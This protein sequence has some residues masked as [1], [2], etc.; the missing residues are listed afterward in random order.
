MFEL[1]SK[2][3]KNLVWLNFSKHV[4]AREAEAVIGKAQGILPKLN[5]GFRLVTDLSGLESM[6]LNC[7]PH[8]KKL[9]EIWNK[10]GVA[11]VI[12]IIPD[13]SKDI[14]L[15]IMS[16][17]HYRRRIPIVTCENQAEAKKLLSE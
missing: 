2:P 5:P 9:M 16:L 4:D 13:P 15:S 12:R 17:F 6:D 8:I 14:G 1:E 11:K 7:A 10:A 3:A